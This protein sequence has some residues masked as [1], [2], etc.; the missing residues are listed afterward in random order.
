MHMDKLGTTE[1]NTSVLT[2]AIGILWTPT[3]TSFHSVFAGH[4]C[5]LRSAF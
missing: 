1:G 2:G 3:R 5:T 4:Y